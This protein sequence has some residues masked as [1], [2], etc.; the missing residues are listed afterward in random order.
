[1][2]RLS[3]CGAVRSLT[4]CFGASASL[5][6]FDLKKRILEERRQ[7]EMERAGITEDDEEYVDPLE[8]ERLEQEAAARESEKNKRLKEL[9]EEAHERFLAKR[10]DQKAFRAQMLKK[11][12][13]RRKEAAAR[14][15]GPHITVSREIVEEVDETRE[16]RMRDAGELDKSKDY[17][18]AEGENDVAARRQFLRDS[19]KEH[20]PEHHN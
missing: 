17:T 7:R 11:S 8:K 14:A 3:N 13:L 10:Q 15:S 5:L 18:F 6:A 2:L 16:K 4:R 20:P 9:E 12:E 19:M 1:M